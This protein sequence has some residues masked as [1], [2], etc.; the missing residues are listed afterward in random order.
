MSGTQK[1]ELVPYP[2]PTIKF[3]II[4]SITITKRPNVLLAAICKNAK[5]G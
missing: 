1:G 5:K 2:I 3:P 4:N